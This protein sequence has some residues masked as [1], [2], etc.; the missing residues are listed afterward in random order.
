MEAK[1]GG[2]AI[3]FYYTGDADQ[4]GP[5]QVPNSTILQQF[6]MELKGGKQN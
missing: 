5:F 4:L 6:K 3:I 2:S 1:G